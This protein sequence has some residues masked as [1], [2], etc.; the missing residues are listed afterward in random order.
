MFIGREKEMKFVKDELKNNR[1]LTLTG[2]GGAGKTRFALQTAA[3]VIDEFENGVWFV[4]LSAL[5]DVVWVVKAAIIL[6]M[7]LFEVTGL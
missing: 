5:K 4:D 6:F 2:T 3:D 7:R 1:L